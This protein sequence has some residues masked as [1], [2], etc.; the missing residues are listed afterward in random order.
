MPGVA[1]MAKQKSVLTTGEI[2]R[3]CSVAPRTVSKWF[4]TGQLRGYRIPGSRDRRVPI[5][6]LIRFMRAHNIPLNGLEEG[7]TRVLIA[8]SDS[9]LAGALAEALAT[10][11]TYEI[12]TATN[13]LEAALLTAWFRPRFLFIDVEMPGFAAADLFR[14]IR[15]HAEMSV[16]HVVA[17]SGTGRESERHGLMELGFSGCLTKPFDAGQVLDIIQSKSKYSE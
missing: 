13:I 9:E 2:A 8:A 15:E 3:I 10:D 4:D 12:R 14:A 11:A 17:I 5:E 16:R 6:Q 7:V 1:S